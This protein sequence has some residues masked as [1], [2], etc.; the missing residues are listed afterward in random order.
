MTN[1][2]RPTIDD[3]K[4]KPILITIEDKRFYCRKERGRNSDDN[5]I[6]RK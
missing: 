1:D 4:K 3:K 5:K 2:L 6:D